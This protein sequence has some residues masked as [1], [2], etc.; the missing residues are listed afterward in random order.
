MMLRYDV[1]CV[2]TATVDTFLTIE[3][4]FSSVHPGDKILATKMEVHSGGSATNAAAALALLGI[5]VKMAV[6]LG[7]D[8]N[9][10]FI[11]QEMRKYKVRNIISQRSSKPTNISTIISSTEECDRVIY[12]YKGASGDVSKGDFRKMQC[13][14]RWLY[15]G[16]LMGSSFHSGCAVAGFIK[17]HQGK[18]LFNPSLYLAKKG[19]GYCRSLLRSTDILVLNKE[20]AQ[21]LAGTQS[22]SFPF[23]LRSLHN[24]G[25]ELVVIT[26][27]RK[28][29]YA[30]RDGKI[31]SLLGPD[32]P[33]V[34]T[35]GAGD[36]FT[37]G[38]LA[39]IVKKWPLEDALRLGQ[40]NATS[41]IQHI[42]TK[43]ILLT[44]K[45]AR[46]QIKKYCIKV[47]VQ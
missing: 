32:V 20:E 24:L 15:F 2:G 1:L 10:S 46:A 8:H 14:A 37:A 26:N 4:P 5:K 25:P 13:R 38:L 12:A 6:K 29:L 21:V 42:G 27:G 19:K 31:Y 30:L 34:H 40:V 44:E 11:L 36:A 18:V 47:N 23:L 43:N 3:Q 28:R 16:T 39:G 45:Q 41:V 7:K 33:I 9:A 22:S 35:A 17:K